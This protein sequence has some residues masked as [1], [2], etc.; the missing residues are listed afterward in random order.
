[1][2]HA[3]STEFGERY[4]PTLF[5]L[6]SN[7]RASVRNA[8]ISYRPQRD[9]GIH[10][11][12]YDMDVIRNSSAKP[13]LDGKLFLIASLIVLVNEAVFAEPISDP[14][15]LVQAARSYFEKFD[16]FRGTW[17]VSYS[18]VDGG[19]R[20]PEKRWEILKDGSKAKVIVYG[21][22]PIPFRKPDNAEELSKKVLERM[23]EAHKKHFTTKE[24][25][26]VPGQSNLHV[27]GP[28]SLIDEL[29]PTEDTANRII[30]N[31]PFALSYGYL[32]FDPILDLLESM[33]LTAEVAEL[34]GLELHVLSAKSRNGELSIQLWFD[35]RRDYVITNI[36]YQRRVSAP[37]ES[38]RHSRVIYRQ[39]DFEEK[40]GILTPMK[41]ERTVIN[42]PRPKLVFDG[43]ER[44]ASKD[45][46]GNVVMIPGETKRSFLELRSIDYAPVLVAAD[47]EPTVPI[48]EGARVTMRDARQLKYE[49]RGG[50]AVPV[51]PDVTTGHKF[52]QDGRPSGRFLMTLVASAVLALVA[53]ILYRQRKHS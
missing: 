15:V 35:P 21:G 24:F 29:T 23:E 42:A 25:I 8:K 20:S 33:E 13:L 50:E 30:G 41:A 32:R 52:S 19:A 31:T 16:T 36:E 34:E 43:K 3:E 53:V 47:F 17:A 48:E 7:Q 2:P 26:T 10:S 40:N 37:S 38:P 45:E 27:Y 11:K 22:T 12:G 1:M 4:N 49:W 14:A 5:S 18:S 9:T 28:D 51:V 44:V 39:R 6:T 46:S